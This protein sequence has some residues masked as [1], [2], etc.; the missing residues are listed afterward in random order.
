MRKLVDKINILQEENNR[1]SKLCLERGIELTNAEQDRD[2]F[3]RSLIASE[4][5]RFK[6]QEENEKLLNEILDLEDSVYELEKIIKEAH[7]NIAAGSGFIN[8]GE[9]SCTCKICQ[10]DL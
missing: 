2:L 5:R 1:L 6:T 4:G 8:N 10:E 7:K 3:D 9:V